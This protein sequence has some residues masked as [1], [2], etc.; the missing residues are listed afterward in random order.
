MF[1]L[2][3]WLVQCLITR[4]FRPFKT[5]IVVVAFQPMTLMYH[6]SCLK[7]IIVAF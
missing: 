4:V 2:V 5:L 6:S 1:I 7:A 3:V